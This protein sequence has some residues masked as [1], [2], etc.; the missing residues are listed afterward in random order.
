M[1]REARVVA[2]LFAWH[3]TVL[4][5]K[6][7]HSPRSIPSVKLFI[8]IP[9]GQLYAVAVFPLSQCF[10][11]QPLP[12]L[13]SVHL[14]LGCTGLWHRPFREV[15]LCPACHR[16]VTALS[17]DTLEPPTLNFSWSFTGE[18]ASLG[19]VTTPLL[20]LPP[21]GVQIISCFLF[22]FSSLSFLHLSQ[23]CGDFFLRCLRSSASV[24][25]VLCVNC[26][27]CRCILDVLVGMSEI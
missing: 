6:A 24:Q 8:S 23:L 2:L 15:S 14:S 18:G 10:S 20:L 4:A 13:V 16:P 12:A 27:T 1:G 21:P 25:R 3:S 5:S 22:S 26:S 11:T 9:S 17:S 7:V 19:V